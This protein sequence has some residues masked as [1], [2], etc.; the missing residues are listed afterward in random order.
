MKDRIA[1][2]VLEPS[3]SIEHAMTAMEDG[4]VT[5][6]PAGIVI[7]VAPGT[8]KIRG[9]VTDGDIRRAIVD[10]LGLE[11]AISEIMSADPLVISDSSSAAAMLRELHAELNR[12]EDPENKYHHIVVVDEDRSILDVVTPFELWKR[13]EVRINTAAVVGL[14]FVGLTFAL[15]LAD[16]GVSIQGI[17]KDPEV[18]KNLRNGVPHFHERGLEPMLDEHVGDTL[19]I[20]DDV[21]A[22]DSDIYV[23]C[24]NTP[25][26]DEQDIDTSA[27]QAAA[28]EVGENLSVHDLVIVRSTV[29]TGTCR[30]VVV[31]TL[32]AASDLVAGQDFFVAYAPERTIAG[33]ALNEL[34]SLP[35]VIGGI[36]KSSADYASQL[37]QMFSKTTVPV[38]SLEAAETVKLLNNSYRDL[39]FAFANE[40]AMICNEWGLDTHEVIHAANEGYDRN[41][42]PSPSPGVGG[43]CL[44]KDPYFLGLSGEYRGYDPVLPAASREVN[45]A[46]I[47][48]VAR[49]VRRFVDERVDGPGVGLFA[50]RLRQAVRHRVAF[51]VFQDDQCLGLDLYLAATFPDL[52]VETNDVVDAD[53]GV[54]PDACFLEG[55]TLDGTGLVADLEDRRTARLARALDDALD[56]NRLADPVGE[57]PD[58]DVARLFGRLLRV[59]RFGVGCPLVRFGVGCPLVRFGVG[60]LL[61]VGLIGVVGLGVGRLRLRGQLVGFGVG[62]FGFARFGRLRRGGN[63]GFGSLLVVGCRVSVSRPVSLVFLVRC[64]LVGVVDERATELVF[65]LADRPAQVDVPVVTHLLDLHEDDVAGLPVETLESLVDLAAVEQSGDAV[66]DVDEHAELGVAVD[67]PAVVAVDRQLVGPV[68]AELEDDVFLVEVAD[69]TV[70][71]LPADDTRS[72]CRERTPGP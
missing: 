4:K 29:V 12:R 62:G 14:G 65:G 16:A 20:H 64:A 8:D 72:H 3:D 41:Q 38:S 49:K 13:S 9:V 71:R 32:E 2:I 56:A 58:G 45:E 23:L 66:A 25:L 19:T 28:R 34:K 6:A 36:N 21:S 31:P 39:R 55:R 15:T 42:I 33:N 17:E 35:Q 7:V 46:M 5:G 53:L 59:V 1:P 43:A 67:G 57:R 68:A 26:D 51:L 60:G 40:T 24:V 18:R 50:E 54:G 37:F 69:A 10:G 22:V 61:V 47:D 11:T 52:A 48:Y 27:L 63:V 30:E 70:D 44:T